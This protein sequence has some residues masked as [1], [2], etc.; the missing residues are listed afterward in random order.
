MWTKAERPYADAFW[1][2]IDALSERY[3][4][5]GLSVVMAMSP[6]AARPLVGSVARV[7]RGVLGTAH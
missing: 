5:D 6:N 7:G 3:G 2:R 4:G 1:M